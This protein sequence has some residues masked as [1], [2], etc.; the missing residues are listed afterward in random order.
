MRQPLIVFKT[1]MLLSL[2]LILITSSLLTGDMAFTLKDVWLIFN[3]HATDLQRVIFYD[4]RLPHT[5]NTFIIGCLLAFS[6]YLMQI[7]LANPLVDPYTL[8]TSGGASVFA[9]LGLLLNANGY[10]LTAFCFAG[11]LISLFLLHLAVGEL[12]KATAQQLVLMGM[13]LAAGWGSLLSLLL[14]IIPA[15]QLKSTLFWLFGD[16]DNQQHPLLAITC[17]LFIFIQS[18]RLQPQ[19]LILSQGTTLAK[20]LG[21]DTEKLQLKIILFSSLLTACA[22]SLGGMIGFVGLIVPHLARTL[23]SPGHFLL[24]PGTTLLGGCLLLLAD[25]AARSLVAPTQLPIGIMTA[26]I[27]IPVF[28]VMLRTKRSTSC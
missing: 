2:V 24:L 1:S 4:I 6:G 12:K 27:G 21:V 20:T 9:L 8:G 28:I 11:S 26:F 10:V 25:L 19:L 17:L 14:I 13:V 22:V 15:S 7:L 16:I 23:L 18:T 3:H 5:I